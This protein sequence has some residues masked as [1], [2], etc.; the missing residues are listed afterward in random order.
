M[1][2]PCVKDSAVRQLRR[3]AGL[4]RRPDYMRDALLAASDAHIPK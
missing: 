2:H 3:G 4:I 1:A